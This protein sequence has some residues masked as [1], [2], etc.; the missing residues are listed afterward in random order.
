[1]EWRS[2]LSVFLF[3]H[4]NQRIV[5]TPSKFINAWRSRFFISSFSFSL[6]SPAE[7]GESSVS[8]P[9]VRSVVVTNYSPAMTRPVFLKFPSL[10]ESFNCS[11]INVNYFKM[12]IFSVLLFSPPPPVS[13]F[14]SNWTCEMNLNW[15]KTAKLRPT[16]PSSR[17]QITYTSN[18]VCHRPHSAS[19]WA[20]ECV[21]VLKYESYCI[22][23]H[24][25]D[26]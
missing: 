18:E 20:R 23:I 6:L 15:D 9:V 5:V 13:H 10:K 1:M 7:P 19:V 24:V 2:A 26:K 4:K 14:Q 3:P 25:L 17:Q 11:V 21:R 8:R 16:C 12:S 22:D